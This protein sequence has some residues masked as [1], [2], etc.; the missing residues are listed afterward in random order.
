MVYVNTLMLQE[1]TIA[2]KLS[3]TRSGGNVSIS[4][5]G[6]GGTLES[7]TELK[8]TNTVWTSI[9]TQNPATISIETGQIRYYRVKQ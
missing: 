4:W 3:I 2:P 9:G 8:P 5:L 1:V 7:A 6:S